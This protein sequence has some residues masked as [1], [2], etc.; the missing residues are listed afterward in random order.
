MSLF[1]T[2]LAMVAAAT[3]VAMILFVLF[4]QVTVRKLRKN[5]KTKNEL[6]MEFVSG[7][8]IINVAQALAVP[9]VIMRKFKN[10][11]LSLLYADVDLLHKHT[12]AFDRLL[13][14]VFYWLLM[15]SGLSGAF[16][17]LLNALGVFDG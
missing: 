13:G 14:S 1:S 8:D 11:S 2:L 16:L 12:N 3:F 7:W 10:T 5:P 17:V 4:G 9:K 15:I 6:G